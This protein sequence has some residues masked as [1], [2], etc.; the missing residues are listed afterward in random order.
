MRGFDFSALTLIATV[1]APSTS[2]VDTPI[3]ASL[4]ERS[5]ICCICKPAWVKSD[6][7]A[8]WDALPVPADA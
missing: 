1:A 4:F 3:S 5:G 2:S 6:A 7:I 8:K